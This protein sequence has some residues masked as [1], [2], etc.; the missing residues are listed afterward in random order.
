MEIKK[1]L[2]WDIS[3][4]AICMLLINLGL[5][6][7]TEHTL[8]EEVFGK[9]VTDLLIITVAA[10]IGK[11]CAPK[12]D[13]PVWWR[14]DKSQSTE[15][16]LFLLAIYGTTIIALNTIIYYSYPSSLTEISWFRF[17][18][19]RELILTAFRAG[20]FE[21]I[22]FRFCIFTTITYFAF[23]L[24]NSRKKSIVIGIIISSLLFG[25]MHGGF[26]IIAML[27]GAALAYIYY[28]YG[29]IPVIII[30]F[31][32]NAIPWSLIYLN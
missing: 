10:L 19:L 31:L 32:A 11:Q 16:Q 12:I 13:S 20:L 23:G 8:N 30:H 6:T 15:K 1:S 3:L 22:L 25:L 14:R 29:L 9:L 26:N 18:N 2:K 28:S 7:F 27:M 24:L 4:I 5:T 17:T 21:E